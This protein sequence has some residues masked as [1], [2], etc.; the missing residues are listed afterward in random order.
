MGPRATRAVWSHHACARGNSSAQT[1]SAPTRFTISRGLFLL[2]QP[3]VSLLRRFRYRVSGVERKLPLGVLPDVT[4]LKAC[5][6]RDEARAVL[7]GV[8][9]W[10]APS[11]MTHRNS[12]EG[13]GMQNAPGQSLTPQVG[14]LRDW[15][16]GR[17]NP[18]WLLTFRKEANFPR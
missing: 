3:N 7:E 5:Q 10:P 4:L 6:K 16:Q 13:S 15:F 17:N 8:R 14:T 1:S 2:V 11:A 9:L 18:K 12:R